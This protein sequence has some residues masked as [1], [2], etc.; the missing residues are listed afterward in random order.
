MEL[1]KYIGIAALIAGNLHIASVLAWYHTEYKKPLVSVKP[2]TCRPCFTF[3]VTLAGGF[4]LSAALSW[5]WIAATIAALGMGLINYYRV[6][7]LI[8]IEP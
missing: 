7:N 2:F 1:I 6:K 5:H 3:W 8:T 4:A